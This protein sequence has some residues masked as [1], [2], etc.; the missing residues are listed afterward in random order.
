M[1]CEQYG[2]V[3]ESTLAGR[4]A[5]SLGA[6]VMW[7]RIWPLAHMALTLACVGCCIY[8]LWRDQDRGR[9]TGRQSEHADLTL[10][11]FQH[12][13]WLGGDYELPR[14]EDHCAVAILRFENGRF[15]GRVGGWAWSVPESGPRAVPFQV[16]W[17]PTATG[18][19][20]TVF[21]DGM[22]MTRSI[23]DDLMGKVDGP[24]GRAFGSSNLGELRG[25]RVIGFAASNETRTGQE[26]SADVS[27]NNAAEAV[28]TRKYVVVVALKP[29]PSAEEA[30]QWALGTEER[31]EAPK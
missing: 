31:A 25:L 16:I 1:R 10:R 17:G 30:R 11:Q 3:D 8:L 18:P 6:L 5:D 15:L 29:F 24:V 23:A 22:S 4:T 7:K 2:E 20:M 13:K 26:Q 14:G 21:T 9:D 19:K 12:V 28:E 27:V